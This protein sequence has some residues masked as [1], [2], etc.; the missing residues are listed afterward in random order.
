ME[1]NKFLSLLVKGTPEEAVGQAAVGGLK[2]CTLMGS[3]LGGG[4]QILHAPLEEIETVVRWFCQE[5]PKTWPPHYPAG[6]L[7]FYNVIGAPTDE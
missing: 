1:Q 4:I 2:N 6:S 5:G 3:A 7:L